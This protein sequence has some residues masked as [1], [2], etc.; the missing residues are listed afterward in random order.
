M[1]SH[2]RKL[3]LAAGTVLVLALIFIIACRTN[4]SPAQAG[5]AM[6]T[7][8]GQA[9]PTTAADVFITPTSTPLPA[10]A[11]DLPASTPTATLTPTQP[12]AS[13]TTTIPAKATAV[14]PDQP[15]AGVQ[16]YETTLTLPTYPIQDYLSEQIDPIYNIPVYYFNRA[17]YEAAASSPTPV[18]Y[19]G[20]VLENAYLRLTFL[21]ALGGRLYSAVVKATDQEIFYHN[22]VVKPSRY[23]V[24][25]P[26]EANW[27]LATG[28]M[29][30]AYPT[31]EHGYRFGVPW[32]YEV[33][34]AEDSAAITLSDIA[35]D[36]VGLE[37]TVTLPADSGLFTVAPSLINH[38]PDTAPV[39]LWL[40]AALTLGSASMS[41]ETR[42]II[43]NDTITVHSRG[44]SGWEVP[45]DRESAAWPEVAST[46]LSDYSQWANYLGF[47]VPNQETPFMGAHNP[48]THL[49]IV[50]LPGD[51]AGSG[52]LFAFGSDFPDRSYTD[53]NSQYFEIWGGANAGF[54]P[55]HDIAVPVGGT[56]GWQESWWP[57]PHLEGLTWA[58]E[59]AAIYLH[60]MDNTYRLSALLS[61]PAQGTLQV[62]T[63]T[64]SLLTET[65]STDPATVLQWDFNADL[66]VRIQFIDDT[67]ETLLT[68]QAN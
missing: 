63:G 33:T 41:P 37:V 60:Q 47:F 29:E 25:Q 21:P 5:E 28:G 58:T 40:N 38:G 59:H 64:N 6:V 30:W 31:Q 23:G 1:N 66:P 34:Q 7:T 15:T 32:D 2:K 52:K 20:I 22:P 12:P 27:W 45:G 39:Q 26:Y 49:G 46:N 67:G 14:L 44:E 16:V 8:L 68:Y 42:F 24:L 19:T 54:W 61:Y 48:A 65:F 4:N 11:T 35:P 36:R 13:P 9:S 10:T 17:A 62:S 3:N 50:R 57:L 43:P 56:L 51:S 55:E 18:D 53:D